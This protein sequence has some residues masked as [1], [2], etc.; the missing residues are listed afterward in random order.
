MT[1]AFNC[2]TRYKI[3]G[4]LFSSQSVSVTEEPVFVIGNQC[5][6]QWQN[7]NLP[8]SRLCDGPDCFSRTSWKIGSKVA[9]I[10]KLYSCVSRTRKRQN[11]SRNRCILGE[12]QWRRGLSDTTWLPNATSD[13]ALGARPENE[14]GSIRSHWQNVSGW[15]KHTRVRQKEISQLRCPKIAFIFSR[16][17]QNNVQFNENE[18]CFKL[19]AFSPQEYVLLFA[20]RSSYPVTELVKPQLFP[21]SG[22]KRSKSMITATQRPLSLSGGI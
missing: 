21:V 1:P 2:V 22:E 16:G 6:R 4:V 9:E 20:P 3:T 17:S 12:G 19:K 18:S 5:H 14:T 15:Q 8:P 13:F 11:K 7:K 10:C